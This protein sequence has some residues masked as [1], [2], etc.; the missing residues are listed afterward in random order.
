MTPARTE[1]EPQIV[2]DM[3]V[4]TGQIVK[5]SQK[6]GKSKSGKA[7]TKYGICI[8]TDT[9]KVWMNTFDKELAAQAAVAMDDKR[10]L[11][12][13][14]VKTQWGYD[15]KGLA[16]TDLSEIMGSVEG[17]GEIDDNGEQVPF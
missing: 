14:A 11:A 4:L 10:E 3:E 8:E 5:V 16:A 2:D 9:G 1:P 13:T 7:Y 12:A 17:I 6:D 15:L